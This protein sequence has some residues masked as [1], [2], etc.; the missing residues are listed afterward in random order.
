MLDS[1][2][3]VGRGWDGLMTAWLTEDDIRPADLFAAYLELVGLDVD[4]YF[5]DTDR[6]PIA[7]P[8]C[9]NAGE[10]VFAKLGFD[11]RE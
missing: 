3:L 11:F 10:P 1:V 9:D 2:V 8:A 7:C 6:R 5:A 4:A